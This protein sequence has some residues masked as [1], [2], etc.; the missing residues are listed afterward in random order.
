M[1]LR[2]FIT[3]WGKGDEHPEDKNNGD[4]PVPVLSMEINVTSTYLAPQTRKHPFF[5]W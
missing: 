1:S 4:C 3:C 5:I 2:D